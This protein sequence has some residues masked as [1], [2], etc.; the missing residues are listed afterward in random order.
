MTTANTIALTQINELAGRFSMEAHRV[1][2][3]RRVWTLMQHRSAVGWHNGGYDAVKRLLDIAAALAGLVVAGPLI[4][5]AAAAIKLTDWGPVFFWQERVGRRGKEFPFV[6]LRSMVRQAETLRTSLLN[7]NHHGESITFKMKD[8]P[9]IT[10]IG[11]L[12]RRTSIDELPQLWC[13]L[14]GKMSLVGPRPPLPSEVRQYS[15]AA[16]R[17]LDVTPGLTCI[18]Q[19]S[20]RGDVPFPEQVKLDVEY[21]ERRSLGYDLRLLLRTPAAVLS[22]RGAY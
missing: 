22:R 13:V 10:R 18:W 9:R 20:G 14:T 8:D 12:I 6:K 7:Q 21:V 1:A 15:V 11:R 4:V 2:W 19:I 16:R 3:L 5:A 17:R